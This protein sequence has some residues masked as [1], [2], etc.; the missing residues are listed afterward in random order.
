MR[1]ITNRRMN[2]EEEN[3][4]VVGIL[5][6]AVNCEQLKRIVELAVEN[7]LEDFPNFVEWRRWIGGFSEPLHQGKISAVKLGL[8]VIS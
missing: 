5:T 3:R 7:G 1:R 2:P 4:I 8:D 6:R